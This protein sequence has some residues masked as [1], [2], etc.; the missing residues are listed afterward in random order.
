MRRRR[1]YCDSN[2]N[3]NPNP[4]CYDDSDS[5]CNGD[6]DRHRDNHQNADCNADPRHRSMDDDP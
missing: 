4:G 1:G 3:R 6:A 5:G 2:G